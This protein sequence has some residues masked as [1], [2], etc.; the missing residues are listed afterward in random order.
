MEEPLQPLAATG[1]EK[2]QK[3]YSPLTPKFLS[4]PINDLDALEKAITPYTCAVM[5]RTH[6]GKAV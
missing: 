3:K 5:L 2:Y 1:Q 6:T 4:V